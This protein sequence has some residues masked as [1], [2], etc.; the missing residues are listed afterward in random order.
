MLSGS[1]RNK[2]FSATICLL[3]TAGCKK[4][5]PI[6]SYKHELSDASNYSSKHASDWISLLRKIVTAQNINPPRA[7]R[8]YGYAG[9]TL[10]ESVVE[11]IEGN[12]TLQ[13]QLNGFLPGSIPEN[14]DSLDY[15]IV[16][17]E[18]LASIVQCDTII[19]NLSSA[20]RDSALALHDRIVQYKSLMV[21]DSIIL[22]SKARGLV[23]ANAVKKY[24]AADNFLTVKNLVYNVPPRDA[25]HLWYWEPTDPVNLKPTEPYWGSMRT[26]ALDSSAQFELPQLI[27]FSTDTSSVFGRQAGEVMTTV[28]NKTPAQNDI[29]L[30]WRDQGGTQTPAG[31]WMG[32]VQYIVP[33]K[34]YNLDKAAELFAL[35]GITTADAFISCWNAKY[36]YNLLRPETYIKAYMKHSWTTGQGSDIT[37][38]FPEYPSGHSVCSGAASQVL[39]DA[40]GTFTF[41]DSSSMNYGYAPR[42][43]TSFY[44]AADEAAMSRLYGGIHYREAIENGITQG[45]SIGEKVTASVKFR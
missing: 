28:E 11:G 25:M 12:K 8:I 20:N 32:I 13:G 31:H 15:D 42:T 1:F 10:Y 26:F 4:E 6:I 14:T 36:R 30:W 23:V 2:V 18:A 40:L 7:S 5:E 24:A 34:N 3:L 19:P 43:Y 41:K 21:E 29:V 16:L 9:I 22:K 33:L 38:P 44:S 39:T 37:P 45:R 17:N 35:V 27:A